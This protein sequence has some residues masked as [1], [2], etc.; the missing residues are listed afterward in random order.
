MVTIRTI[1]RDLA[2]ADRRRR[3][4]AAFWK[5]ADA[6]SRAIATAQLAKAVHFREES[7]RKLSADKRGEMLANRAGAHEFEE[8]LA[9]ALM[10]YHTHEQ[11]EM[12]AAF[13]DAWKI[14]HE[15]GSIETDEYKAPTTDEVR[16]AVTALSQFDRRDVAI[17]LATAG[18][19]MGEEW[20]KA[21]TPVVEEIA[22]ALTVSE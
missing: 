15:N 16:D 14:P 19:L 1:F 2:D 20:E 3:I 6:Q 5:H 13:L 21:T 4:G 8:A 7:L 12:L 11:R 17:Y 10:H 22:P 18:L 9:A